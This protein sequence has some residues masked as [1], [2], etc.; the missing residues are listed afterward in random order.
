MVSVVAR[1]RERFRPRPGVYPYF[2]YP[3]GRRGENRRHVQKNYNKAKAPIVQT[4][5]HPDAAG[6]DL[7]AEV[8]YVAVPTDR[9]PQ[10]VRNFGTTTEQLYALADWLQACRVQTVP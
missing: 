10:P 1:P 6:I 8:H 9:D 7:A 3:S 5:V 2:S 4:V